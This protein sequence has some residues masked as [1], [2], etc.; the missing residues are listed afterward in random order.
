ML[1]RVPHVAQAGKRT[2]ELRLHVFAD[3][4]DFVKDRARRDFDAAYV[5]LHATAL[6]ELKA[7]E[8]GAYWVAAM[9]V[10]GAIVIV[11]QLTVIG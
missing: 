11:G 4:G 6:K 10:A 9:I 1:Q 2:I 3:V 8:Y 7:C 5:L